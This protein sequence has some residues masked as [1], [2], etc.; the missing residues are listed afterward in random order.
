MYPVNYLGQGE[1]MLPVQRQSMVLHLSIALL[2]YAAFPYLGGLIFLIT[3]PFVAYMI[4]RPKVQYLPALII[5]MQC[6]GQAIYV[7]ALICFVFCVVHFNELWKAKLRWVFL[8]YLMFAP[9]FLWVMAK[10]WGVRVSAEFAFYH[11]SVYAMCQYC[12]VAPFFWAVIA[13]K[14][15]PKDFFQILFLLTIMA[16][17]SGALR[18]IGIRQYYIPQFFFWAISYSGAL[19]SWYIWT[20][21][22]EVT[23]KMILLSLFAMFFLA[24]F[25]AGVVVSFTQFG[26]ALI[27]FGLVFLLLKLRIAYRLFFPAAIMLLSTL[28]VLKSESVAE[29][30]Q[31]RYF[32]AGSYDELSM[33][34]VT[35]VLERI[36]RKAFDDRAVLWAASMR[37]IKENFSKSIFGVNPYIRPIK[38][39]YYNIKWQKVEVETLLPSHNVFLQLTLAYGIFGIAFYFL[40]ITMPSLRFCF[41]GALIMQLT[42]YCPM[43]IA[44]I[45]FIVFASFSGGAILNFGMSFLILGLL[46]AGYRAAVEYN[47]RP[48]V[49]V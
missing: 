9:F 38:L 19:L 49:M 18:F 44:S 47:K 8:L 14:R 31:G 16:W 6:G 5:Y 7:G 11:G 41:K 37:A 20:R 36:E 35:K 24:F 39:E 21:S 12:S 3:T 15:L 29:K 30:N 42:P 46:G 43:M 25:V 26:L 48:R 33:T 13:F 4:W 23:K 34:S 28:Y 32:G 17:F 2:V 1:R 27:S 22:K 45:T 10:R 40:I